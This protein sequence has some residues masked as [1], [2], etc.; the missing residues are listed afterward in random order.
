MPVGL[1]PGLL[2]ADGDRERLRAGRVG[3]AHAGVESLMTKR[4]ISVAPDCPIAD[5]LK[6]LHVYRISCIVVCEEEIPIGVI[7]ERDAV[8]IAYNLASGREETRSLA[9]ELMSSSVTT[10]LEGDSLEDAIALVES[11]RI[12]HLPVV[13]VSGRLVGLLTQTDLLRASLR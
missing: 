8:G 2:R 1:Q 9:R 3:L 5:V 13:D 12:R 7:S 6:K 10:I 4:V 11:E